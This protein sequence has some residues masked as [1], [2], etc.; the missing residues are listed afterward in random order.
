MPLVDIA[1]LA[2]T[3]LDLSRGAVATF[4]HGLAAACIGFSVAYGGA[5]IRWADQWF[6]HKFTDAAH[7]QRAPTHGPAL[8]RYEFV[9]WFRCVLA[10]IVTQ[11]LMF[12]AITFV[13]IIRP[14]L[15]NSSYGI[16]Y[17]WS[18]WFSGLS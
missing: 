15:Q 10:V 7:P 11:V 9:W 6:A 5:S 12:L 13:D 3:T 18:L 16:N 2:A 14:T 17:P 1:L 4:A 8:I